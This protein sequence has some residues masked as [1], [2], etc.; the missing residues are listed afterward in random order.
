MSTML[1]IT[2][3][4]IDLPERLVSVL[5]AW[6]FSCKRLPGGSP[7]ISQIRIH[8]GSVQRSMAFKGMQYDGYNRITYFRTAACVNVYAV[9]IFY[10]C[11]YHCS[12]RFGG[13]LR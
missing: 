10:G 2:S 5:N 9:T 6:P 11:F 12:G 4:D 1:K 7:F 13:E 8:G 3:A